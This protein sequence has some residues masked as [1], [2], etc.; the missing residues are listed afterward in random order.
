MWYDA[1]TESNKRKVRKHM[2]KIFLLLLLL[3]V[4]AVL[5][6][7][8]AFGRNTTGEG[9]DSSTPKTS[10]S[11]VTTTAEPPATTTPTGTTKATAD[12]AAKP[13]DDFVT[14]TVS[15][16]EMY[17]GS[18]IL[19]DAGNPYCYKVANLHTPTELER[20]SATELS[21]LGWTS[22][23][24]NKNGNFLLRSRLIYLR[25]E[26]FSSFS[27]MMSSFVAKTNLRNVQVRY[28]YQLVNSTADA[29][30]LADERVTGLVVELNVLTEEG[31]FS[32]DHVSK[33]DVYYEWFANNCHRYG[34]VM[35]GESGYFRYVGL[36]H[37]AYMYKE[38]IDLGEYLDRLSGYSYE[39]PLVI[40]DG[41]SRL[42]E[43]YSVKATAGTL[44]DI[45]IYKGSVY[46]LSGNNRD[47]FI[48]ASRDK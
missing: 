20:L 33:R 29:T 23:Y 41:D 26:A 14:V 43:V 45:R 40:V 35:T 28:G 8:T 4:T 48:V 27:L 15:N 31:T 11:G 7:C 46:T 5:A 30:S 21:N 42:W 24:N 25:N 18:L 2:K 22:L 39:N 3:T 12:T 19:V 16:T 34:F 44:T 10:E 47:G 37:A 1:D 36:P 6:S 13:E 17:T 38:G 9:A 32:I